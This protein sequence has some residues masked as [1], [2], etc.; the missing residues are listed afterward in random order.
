MKLNWIIQ[1]TLFF[2]VFGLLC[3]TLP[4]GAEARKERGPD[5]R[6]RREKVRENRQ[7]VD[8]E[9]ERINWRELDLSQEQ[10]TQLKGLRREFQVAT[11][12]IRKE[13]ALAKEELQTEIRRDDIDREKLEQ[14][15][16]G[17]SALK[18]RLSEA[19]TENLLA[20]KGILTQE[21]REQLAASQQL[22]PKELRVL[23]LSDEQKA[24]IHTLF[25]Q[26][27]RQRRKLSNELREL[28]SDLRSLLLSPDDPDSEALK[29]LQA[30]IAEKEIEL[31]WAGVENRLTLRGILNPDQL[32]LLE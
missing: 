24:E 19:A 28:K 7:L 26:S 5:L 4:L 11:A 29:E 30:Q 31:E 2:I 18:Q 17:I 10:L 16:Q 20:L 15:V 13:L 23:Q 1:R 21:Q 22:L 32:K 12:G 9:A 6:E 25:K 8:D 27:L 14:M 3:L